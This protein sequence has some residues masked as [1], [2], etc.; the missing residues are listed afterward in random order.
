MAS[1]PKR[2]DI[3]TMEVA[4]VKEGKVGL[5]ATV[6]PDGGSPGRQTS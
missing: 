3:D 5:G 2:C 4:A 1:C 6:V